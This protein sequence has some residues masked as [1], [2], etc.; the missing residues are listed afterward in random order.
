LVYFAVPLSILH[1][2]W[3]ERDVRDWVLV[4]L[5]VV[6]LLFIIR[7]PAIRHAIAHRRHHSQMT[8]GGNKDAG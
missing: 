5:A 8:V 2:F 7:V 1:Y 6:V 3:L 4:Y